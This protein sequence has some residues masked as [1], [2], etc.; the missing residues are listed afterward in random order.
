ML[1]ELVDRL[2]RIDRQLG[3]EAGEEP[4]EAAVFFT[5]EYVKQDLLSK[6]TY[7]QGTSAVVTRIHTDRRGEITHVDVRL[8]DGKFVREVPVDYFK[9]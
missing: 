5:K 9:A 1:E 7:A 4:D 2:R 6:K 8:K 3:Q